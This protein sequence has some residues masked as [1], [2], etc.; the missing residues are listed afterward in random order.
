MAIN[1]SRDMTTELEQGFVDG[2]Y[3][4]LAPD[5][6]GEGIQPRWERLDWPTYGQVEQHPE[7]PFEDHPRYCGCHDEVLTRGTPTTFD[8]YRF[9]A[10]PGSPRY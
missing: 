10:P 5:W 7:H 3:I 8:K 6:G 9:S 4:H 2:S 1:Q